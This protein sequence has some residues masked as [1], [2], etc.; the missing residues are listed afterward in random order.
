MFDLGQQQFIAA[1]VRIM[2]IIV[3]AMAAGIVL[4][5]TITLT[6]PG[7]AHPLM[8][9]KHVRIVTYIAAAYGGVT[10]AA[11]P[12]ISTLLMSAGMRRM[13]QSPPCES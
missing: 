13:A 1:R 6:V 12:L 3:L 8:P 2:R 9:E 7:L 5:L 4:F 11:A 10:L